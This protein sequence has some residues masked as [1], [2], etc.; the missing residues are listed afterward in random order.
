MVQIC[1][2]PVC[3]GMCVCVCERYFLLLHLGGAQTN[4]QQQ[5]VHF[6]G[7]VQKDRWK[8]LLHTRRRVREFVFML[9]LSRRQTLTDSPVCAYHQFEKIK[10]KIVFLFFRGMEDCRIF[11]A[12]VVFLFIFSWGFFFLFHQTLQEELRE[13]SCCAMHYRPNIDF[14]A[15]ST[16]LHTLM[17]A[18]DDVYN[19]QP[20]SS[21]TTVAAGGKKEGPFQ[22]I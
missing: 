3:V 19:T 22:S 9:L 18:S 13:S 4:K 20:R 1:V 17:N 21:R 7:D 5:P 8:L 14:Q 2:Q 6:F 15:R 12:K 11:L 10:T 16:R